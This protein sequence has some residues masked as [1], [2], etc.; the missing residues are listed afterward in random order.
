MRLASEVPVLEDTLMR[1]LVIGLS[2]DLPLGAADAVDLADQLIKRAAYL[3]LD[4]K[5]GTH[6]FIQSQQLAGFSM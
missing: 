3:S 2:P 6:A 1:V 5:I 4:G